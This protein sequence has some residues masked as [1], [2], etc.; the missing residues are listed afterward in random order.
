MGPGQVIFGVKEIPE[1]KILPGKAYV[2]FSHTVKGQK[3][4]R[5]L[6]KKIIQ[7][8]STLIDYEK[9]TDDQNRR[10]IYFGRFAGDAGA[11]DILSL[12]G[13]YWNHH[14]LATPLT[15]IR[16]AHQY[17]TSAAAKAHIRAVGQI[18]RL[19]GLPTE[20]S[21][22]S[23]GILGYGNVSSGAQQV[24]D[25]LPNRHIAPADL[26]GL[27]Q[28]GQSDSKTVYI[29]I[30]KEKDIVRAKNGDPFD[31]QDYY[32]HPERYES[33]FAQYL[34]FL[35]LLVNAV[36]WEARYPR[37]VTWQDLKQLFQAYAKP[38]LSGIADITCDTHG[39]MECNM[40]ATDSSKPAYL[41]DPL[42]GTTTDGHL[43]DG[44][45]LLAV[46]NLPCELPYDASTFFSHQL[47]PMAVNIVAAN[48][49]LP[50]E[51][52]GLCPEVRK[53]VIIYQGQL[54]PSYEY[55]RAYLEKID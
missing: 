42:T 41:C 38:K 26:P 29:C 48:F 1:E 52:S 22:L 25:C 43:G 37:F 39:S 13:E 16:R 34:P 20:L 45:V 47:K 18:I 35:T 21:P 17:P 11:I 28:A 33:I 14:G 31:L 4:G 15:D 55:L 40:R 36:Y 24:F 32:R 3:A 54:T 6:L 53:A 5:P 7:S 46:D 30:F 44:I 2:F 12:M 8:G 50:L 23:I 49:D 10:L 19:N 27:V 9:I 51:D